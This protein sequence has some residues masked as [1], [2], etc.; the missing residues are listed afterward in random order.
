MDTP[1]VS[2]LLCLMK[3]PT[4]NVSTTINQLAADV[5]ILRGKKLLDY[6]NRYDEKSIQKIRS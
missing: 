5:R 1:K 3:L 6:V 2:R 4:G